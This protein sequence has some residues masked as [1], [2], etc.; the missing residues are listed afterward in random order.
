MQLS[1]DCWILL[2]GIPGIAPKILGEGAPGFLFDLGNAFANIMPLSKIPVALGVLITG[3]I[4]GLDGSGFSGL[5]LVG[6]LA[7]A[8][9]TPMGIDVAALAS[10]GQIGAIF[11][12][13]GTLTA[14]AFGLVAVAGVAGVSPQELARKNFIPVVC[15]L[16][17]AT[18]V[19]I[20]MM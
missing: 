16:A 1:F 8:L 14:W 2:Y 7:N 12:G 19:G 5:P 6:S 11:S 15:G 4:T 17:A 18:I 9:G 10:L 20:M 3:V 13:G